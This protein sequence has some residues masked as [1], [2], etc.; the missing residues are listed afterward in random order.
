MLHLTGIKY[1]TNNT[2]EN[3]EPVNGDINTV[4]KSLHSEMAYMYATDTLKGLAILI[5]DDDM[6]EVV[7]QQKFKAVGDEDV[8][9]LQL[10]GIQY[11]V[12]GD[13]I[14]IPLAGYT[15]LNEAYARYHQ[16]MEYMYNAK[17]L[18]GCGIKIF[19]ETLEDIVNE[20]E[21]KMIENTGA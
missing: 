7:K 17:T 9:S 2:N 21:F 5:V 13:N 11:P 16:E 1:L 12:E 6:N 4:M 10:T 15:S 3:V 14:I 8:Q 19:K 18:R 20:T